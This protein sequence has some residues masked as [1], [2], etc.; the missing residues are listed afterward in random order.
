MRDNPSVSSRATA[1][2]LVEVFFVVAVAAVLA[3]LLTPLL[4][5]SREEAR[6]SDCMVNLKQIGMAISLY[7]AEEGYYP[8]SCSESGRSVDYILNR[9]MGF[10]PQGRPSKSPSALSASTATV[11][12]A[13]SCPARRIRT[14]V[15]PLWNYG[16]HPLLCVDRSDPVAPALM[17]YGKVERSGS[18]ILGMDA[19]QD[20][21]GY[22]YVTL[23]NMAGI[24]NAG[25]RATASRRVDVGPDQDGDSYVGNARYRHAGRSVTLFVDSHVEALAKGELKERQIKVSY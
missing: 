5:R 8:P 24:T 7:G 16:L 18:L 3:S 13:V 17:P 10:L 19:T 25:T 11:G 6:L 9:Q 1:F 14:T 23:I 4:Q 15:D 22:S 20:S 12:L 21:Y 2:T